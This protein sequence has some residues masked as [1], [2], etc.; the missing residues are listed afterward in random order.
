MHVPAQYLQ[1][2]DS[3]LLPFKTYYISNAI[4]RPSLADIPAGHYSYYWVAAK[5]TRIRHI[6]QLQR[7]CLPL[8]FHLHPFAML[9]T[10]A[11]TNRLISIQTIPNFTDLFRP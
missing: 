9:D 6:H 11:N 10:L 2:L 5:Q 7:P 1:Q 8:S 3:L 4:V